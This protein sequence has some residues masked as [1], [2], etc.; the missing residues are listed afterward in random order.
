[1]G[2]RMSKEL[3]TSLYVA[4]PKKILSTDAFVSF[5]RSEVEDLFPPALAN[6]FDRWERRGNKPF[7]SVV[8]A[9]Q[10]IVPQIE[11]WATEQKVD[12]P[13]HWKVELAKRV[14]QTALGKA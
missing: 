4:E 10:P 12:L 8:K 2:K 5:S 6:V 9:G 7:P 11:A 14:K 3:A 13:D 1:M